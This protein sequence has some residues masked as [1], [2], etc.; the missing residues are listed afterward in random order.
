MMDVARV[1]TERLRHGGKLTVLTG[2]GVSAESGVPTF[3]DMGGLWKTFDIMQ[4]ATPEAF[5]RDPALVHDFYNE[6]RSKLA[7]VHPNAGHLALAQLERA[8][9]GRFTLITQNVDDLHERA[10]TQRIW[11]MHGELLKARCTGCHD[12]VDWREA[13]STA[14]ACVRCSKPLR[15]HIVWFG[16]VPFHMDDV[17]PEALDCAVFMSVGTSGVVYPA[18]GLVALARARGAYTV[19]VNLER[20]ASAFDAQLTGKSAELLPKLTELLAA[21]L[22]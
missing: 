14:D 3:R 6:R 22:V 8:L 7:G 16:E 19:E 9:G 21:S 18:A 4:V 15:P 20:T 11:H 1:I 10:G 5:A 12:V 13:L 17:I 2:A